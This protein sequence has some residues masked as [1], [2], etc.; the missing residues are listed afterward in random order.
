MKAVSRLK[1]GS[2]LIQE[3]KLDVKTKNIVFCG[4]FQKEMLILLQVGNFAV[5]IKIWCCIF[6]CDHT[7]AA[8]LMFN[9]LGINF[10]ALVLQILCIGSGVLCL[11]NGYVWRIS[12]SS[13]SRGWQHHGKICVQFNALVC[14][15]IWDDFFC[16]SKVACTILAFYWQSFDTGTSS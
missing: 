3:S 9:L 8:G 12:V 11:V 1:P 6:C 2:L 4:R 7:Y 13:I 16:S 10:C 14:I 15:G 5:G